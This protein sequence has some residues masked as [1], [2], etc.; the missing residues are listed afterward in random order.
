MPP[1]VSRALLL[2]ATL[3]VGGCSAPSPMAPGAVNSLPLPKRYD[4]TPYPTPQV[5]DSLL[6]LFNDSRLRSTV[7]RALANNPDLKAS[8]ARL[9]E[10]GF[11]TRR[12]S[13]ALYPSLTAAF[14]GT[15]T[16]S[17]AT[18]ARDFMSAS[19]DARWEIDVWGR[20]RA[21]VS[22]A[23]ADQ[24]AAEADH[25]SARQS[26]AAQTMQAWFDL[27]AA[28]KLVDL[29]QRKRDNFEST[30]NLVGRRFELGTA[31]LGDLELAKADA[32]NAR[33][34][35]E[36]RRDDRDRAAR[37]LATLLGDYPDASRSASGSWPSLNRSVA[38]GLPSDLLLK[39]PDI[40]AAYQRIRA[41]DARIKVAHADLFPSFS[42]TAG[43]G[44]TSNRLASL[45]RSSL[46]AWSLVAGLTAPLFDA[47]ERQAELGAAGKRAEQAYQNWRST[48]LN[49]FREV[50][51]A[52]GSESFLRSQ[53]S[54]R[55]AALTAARKAEAKT[56]RD[57]EAG[58]A[59]IL[60]LLVAQRLV[61]NTEE[62]TINL[63]RTRLQNRVR[64][65][66]ALGKAT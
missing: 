55:L 27:V 22:A 60:S 65:A 20:I 16:D 59:E 11:N 31:G 5:S 32:E 12:S 6:G 53:E 50:E 47:G 19:L 15:R 43:G 41:A 36:G 2:V 8:Q 40:D 49:A 62:Q 18:R 45:A 57:Y 35:L 17:P 1:R 24:A 30:K 61:F 63:H 14:S 58:I 29:G 54:A 28:E 4:A 39:R 44:R 46:D 52:L 66:L 56:R 37:T 51:D 3:W 21:G 34:D 33:A 48:V 42:L 38:A 10:A 23:T 13:A 9:E 25:R 7:N 26:L 64:L